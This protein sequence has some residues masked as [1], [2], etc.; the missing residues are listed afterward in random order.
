[1]SGSLECF[2]AILWEHTLPLLSESWDRC[3]YQV[4]P[5]GLVESAVRALT[6]ICLEPLIVPYHQ[7]PSLM[8]DAPQTCTSAPCLSGLKPTSLFQPPIAGP[9]LRPCPLP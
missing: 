6:V 7:S 8:A 3:D 5:L 9:P 4:A 1:M 2:H